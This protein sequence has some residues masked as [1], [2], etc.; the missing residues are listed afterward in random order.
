[1][2]ELGEDIAAA[3]WISGTM[4][5]SRANKEGN[6]LMVMFYKQQQAAAAMP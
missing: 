3:G 6:A 4:S 5:C 2:I 1:M